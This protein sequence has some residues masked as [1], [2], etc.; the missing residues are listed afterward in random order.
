VT[1][2]EERTRLLLERA[3]TAEAA[4]LIAL[5]REALR[6]SANLNE[7]LRAVTSHVLTAQS[8]VLSEL[9]ATIARARRS[10][11]TS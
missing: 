6:L 1:E 8:R 4:E 9:R 7:R 3:A 10:D 5:A 2:Y 11:E